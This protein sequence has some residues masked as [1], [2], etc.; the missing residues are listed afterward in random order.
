MENSH[1]LVSNQYKVI[2][3]KIV[4]FWLNNKDVD[5]WNK[6]EIIEIDQY[7]YGKLF[8]DKGAIV[9]QWGKNFSKW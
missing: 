1:Y 2:V 8:F 9:I 7:R 4:W 6:I 3:I 5:Q